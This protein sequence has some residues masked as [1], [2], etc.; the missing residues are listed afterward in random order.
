MSNS[1]FLIIPALPGVFPSEDDSSSNFL[2]AQVTPLIPS[3]SYICKYNKKADIRTTG[4]MTTRLK[5]KNV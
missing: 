1:E 5:I 4:L 2:V 3:I